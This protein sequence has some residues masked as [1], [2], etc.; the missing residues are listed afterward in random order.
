MRLTRPVRRQQVTPGAARPALDVEGLVDGLVRDP[1]AVIVPVLVDF[2]P[3]SDLERSVFDDVETLRGS[4]LIPG[5][6]PITGA[7]YDVKS[8]RVLEVIRK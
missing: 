3:F 4:E 7:I 5:D 8:G 1:H 2:L 6:I